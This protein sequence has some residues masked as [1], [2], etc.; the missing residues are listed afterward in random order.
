MSADAS[1]RQNP[2]PDLKT[3]TACGAPTPEARMVYS[4]SGDLVCLGCDTA[5]DGDAKLKR[6][7]LGSAA[8]AFA[9]GAAGF[10]AFW[11]MVQGGLGSA[12]DWH[13]S[14]GMGYYH[15]SAWKLSMQAN[16][17]VYLVC[18]LVIVLAG[19]TIRGAH[20][21]MNAP[22]VRKAIGESTRTRYLV[23][24]WLGIPTPPVAFALWIGFIALLA[25]TR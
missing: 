8:A 17:A 13:E 15:D 21:T 11:I 22:Q 25:A 7:A 23:F 20:R 9:F 24:A 14:N 18:V 4:K 16:T 19:I 10:V 3:C 1:Y 5:V 6:G 2:Q 12:G